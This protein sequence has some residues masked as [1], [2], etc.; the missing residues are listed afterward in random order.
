VNNTSEIGCFKIV[1]ESSVASGIRRVEALTSFKAIEFLFSRN[2]LLEESAK[3]IGVSPN[4]IKEKVI[5]LQQN[6]KKLL[7]EWKNI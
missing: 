2:M 6:L 4:E 3:V 1:S 5:E 7:K